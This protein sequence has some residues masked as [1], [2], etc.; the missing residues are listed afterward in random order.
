[1][2]GSGSEKMMRQVTKSSPKNGSSQTIA[3]V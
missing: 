1:M 2:I 3:R